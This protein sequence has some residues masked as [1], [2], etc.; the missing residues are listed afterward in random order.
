[1]DEN[2]KKLDFAFEPEEE[3]GSVGDAPGANAAAG[4]NEEATL[5]NKRDA[6]PDGLDE[7][8]DPDDYVTV[9]EDDFDY[10]KAVTEQITAQ[11]GAFFEERDEQEEKKASDKPATKPKET[12]KAPAAKGNKEDIQQKRANRKSAEIQKKKRT[13]RLILFAVVVLIAFIVLVTSLIN[14][15]RVLVR[16]KT[17]NIGPLPSEEVIVH[18]IPIYYDYSSDVPESSPVSDSYFSDA[19]FVGD[20]R[21][22]CLD[23]YGVG[24]F[25]TLLYGTS[26]DVT[27]ALSYSCKSSD[28]MDGSLNDKVTLN[29]YG[30]IYINLG[31]N[32]L[33]WSNPDTFATNYRLLVEELKIK[34]PNAVLYICG[35][36]PVSYNRDGRVSY[37]TNDRIQKYNTLLRTVATDTEVYFIDCYS[38]IADEEGY[39][40]SEQT[41]DGINLLQEGCETW[42]NYLKSHTV[43][44]EDYSN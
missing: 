1:M 2:E 39:L 10:D 15:V 41:S 5:A 4:Q 35:I 12:K 26:I 42:Y 24:N 32:E 18:K 22:Q 33:G 14:L 17:E 43:N 36:M 38:G 25:Q 29:D 13:R 6:E 21:V 30:K 27:T 19:L 40:P 31:M 28:G 7:V 34:Q 44:P 37:I 9:G 20:T 23:L 8:T 16:G 11:I 3:L